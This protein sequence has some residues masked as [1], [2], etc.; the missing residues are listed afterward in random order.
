M[1]RLIMDKF[2]ILDIINIISTQLFWL[3]IIKV[4][5]LEG[6]NNFLIQKETGFTIGQIFSY[7]NIIKNVTLEKMNDLMN[8]LFNLDYNI[9]KNIV[10]PYTSFKILIV[11]HAKQ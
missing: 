9:K 10:E 7:S 4:S 1:D 6:K 11:K 5:L 2:S 3:K 8:F